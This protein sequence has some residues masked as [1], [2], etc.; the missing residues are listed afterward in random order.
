MK[1]IYI[2][3]VIVIVLSQALQMHRCFVKYLGANHQRKLIC[4]V[5]MLGLGYCLYLL[6]SHIRYVKLFHRCSFI[7]F[8]CTLFLVSFCF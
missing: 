8:S 4:V 5:S 3:V 6:I 2:A 1:E 7:V